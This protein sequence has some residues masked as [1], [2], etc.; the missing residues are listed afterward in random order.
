M[1]VLVIAS[2]RIGAKIEEW[3]Q[4]ASAACAGFAVVLAA[5]GLGLGAMWK[6]VPFTRGT[7]L[8]DLLGLTP[9]EQLLG[10]VNV[11]TPAGVPPPR[12]EADPATYAH[13]L[14]HTTPVTY[15]P[16]Q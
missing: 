5:H 3:E 12:P 10:W 11:G 2:P 16:A 6:S 9:D 4:Q 15:Q 1:Q 13:V 14:R 7:G 8:T